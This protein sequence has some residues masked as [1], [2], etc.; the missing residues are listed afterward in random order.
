MQ[1]D[2]TLSPPP[3]PES[4]S[5]AELD[6][7]TRSRLLR[8]AVQVFD[9][10]GYS[11]ASVREIVEL[12]SVTKP[13]LYYHFG[14]KE[15]IL[16]A[17]LQEGLEE[18]RKTTTRAIEAPGTTRERLSGLCE[19]FYGLFM[20]NVPLIRVV[21]RAFHDPAGVVP[22]FD[23]MA[24]ERSL[25]EAIGRVVA[26]GVA[27][28]EMSASDPADVALALMGVIGAAASRHLHAGL[29]PISLERLRRVLD[30][31]FDGVVREQREQ[32]E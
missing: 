9:K 2:P 29:E 16:V 3:V 4:V 32:G 24:F 25:E 15:G 13:A 5:P 18:F 22:Q 8:A 26:D 17:I 28:G 19:G 20:E 12:A 10:K 7:H 31:V 23:L 1:P 30:L 6:P 27:A 21:H 11:A 14:S